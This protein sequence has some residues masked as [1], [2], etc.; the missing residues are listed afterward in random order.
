MFSKTCFRI[1]SIFIL[2]CFQ[3]HVEA[4]SPESCM[5]FSITSQNTARLGIINSDKKAADLTVTNLSGEI[6][7]QKTVHGEN[8]YFQLLNLSNMPDGT[9]SI[10]FSNGN[11]ISQKRFTITN[12][13]ARI[14]N[15]EQEPEP[16]FI[17]P[18]DQ[19]LI[20]SYY[21]IN[22]NDVNIFFLVNDEVVFEDRGL[23][24]IAFSKKYSL[25]RLPAGEYLVKLY[26]G[27]QVY[28]YPFA[29][30]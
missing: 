3:I 10:L 21:N 15:E 29:L 2:L 16:K 25:Q 4:T 24:D 30:N 8:N 1:S 18:D 27:G 19:T 28:S 17:R 20:V 12:S 9:Y 26:S 14:I 13:L 6:F 5:L 22:S 7:F 11:V 23:T